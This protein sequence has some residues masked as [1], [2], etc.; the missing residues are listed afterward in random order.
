MPSSLTHINLDVISFTSQ[1]LRD[2]PPHLQVLELNGRYDAD[3]NRVSLPSSLH[4]LK[5]INWIFP[6]ID[7]PTNLHKLTVEHKDHTIISPFHHLPSG[8]KFYALDVK[9]I[10]PPFVELPLLTKLSVKCCNKED[11]TSYLPNTP[12]KMEL[13]F[14][15]F[16]ITCPP[17]LLRL[18][19]ADANTKDR[20][21]KIEATVPKSLVRLTTSSH[22][23]E[24]KPIIPNLNGFVN[25][26][27]T[28]VRVIITEKLF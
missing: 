25:S 3:E 6:S 13:S 26:L 15:L 21:M 17:N 24:M 20:S 27:R 4:S 8:L 14:T 5:T 23:L 12:Q 18:T 16:P 2:L 1:F 7:L 28:K 11:I 19:I 22:L 10:V 9:E